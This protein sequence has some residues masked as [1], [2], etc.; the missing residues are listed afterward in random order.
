MIEWQAGL[1]LGM[2]IL[3]LLAMAVTNIAADVLMMF[4][5]CV[6]LVSG[7]LSPV[8]AFAGFAN[9]GVM[10][11]A[12]LYVVAAGLRETGAVYWLGHWLL[13]RPAT[14][15]GAIGNMIVPIAGLSGLM[16]NTTIVSIFIP[17]IQQWAVRLRISPSQLLM[18]LSFLAIMGGSLTLIGTSTNLV[19]VGLLQ[20][21]KHF[22]LGMFD[23]AWVGLPTLVIGSLFLW[24][25]SGKLLPKRKNPI[26]MPAD[27]RLYQVRVEILPSAPCIGKPLASTDLKHLQHGKWQGIQR[28]R[29]WISE[30]PEQVILQAG[31]VLWLK[32]HPLASQRLRQYPGL[33][34]LGEAPT[35]LS[36]P[37]TSLIE[38]ILSSDFPGLGEPLK[39]LKFW[40]RYQARVLAISRGGN[41]LTQELDEVK[42]TLGDAM[43]LEAGPSFV[44]QYRFRKDFLLVSTLADEP[45]PN[46]RKAPWAM[47]ILFLMLLLTAFAFVP[48]LEAALL[49]A[50][51]MLASGCVNIVKARRYVDLMTLITIAASFALASAMSKTGVSH[52]LV[53][54]LLGMVGTAPLL[55]LILIYMITALLTEL[56]TNNAAAVL[57]F[58]VSTE[59]AGQLGVSF[60][61]FVVAVMM[62][63]SAS[64]LTP[65]GYQTNLMVAGPGGYRLVDF[66]RL[67][68]PLNLI[69]ATVSLAVIPLVWPF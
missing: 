42:L 47:S 57:M 27:A 10:T 62:A 31:D 2:V 1:T 24:L 9:P 67:G 35:S 61:P 11:I 32:G 52:W 53:E 45:P 7:I 12:L 51:A 4:A 40:E 66:L 65:I 25:F 33:K 8:E 15:R 16:N 63:A 19:V 44:E 37:H 29:E 49:A 50:G 60:L 48:M 69:C 68:I 55:A 54:S 21:D 43:L 6:L 41:H 30:D 59:L 20:A 3:V 34:L 26:A 17:V 22:S 58:S 14:Q 38:V 56:V 64:F 5:L 36:A 28:N 18:P 13:G 46:F 23:I 39:M